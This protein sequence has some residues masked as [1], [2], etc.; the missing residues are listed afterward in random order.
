MF[1]QIVIT[2]SLR[3]NKENMLILGLKGLRTQWKKGVSDNLASN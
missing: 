1:K 2:S 3:K